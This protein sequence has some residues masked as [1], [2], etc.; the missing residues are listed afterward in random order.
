MPNVCSAKG[1]WVKHGTEDH[2]V[3]NG[4]NVQEGFRLGKAPMWHIKL[5]LS[6]VRPL[7]RNE[8]GW[9]RTGLGGVWKLEVLGQSSDLGRVLQ[10]QFV[11][12]N[13]KRNSLWLYFWISLELLE[14]PILG[15]SDV[16]R[17]ACFQEWFRE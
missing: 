1:D 15:S 16:F 13:G 10:F 4:N 9:V 6:K 2:E 11:V 5:P 12:V 7:L 3:R 8:A 14:Y 17:G